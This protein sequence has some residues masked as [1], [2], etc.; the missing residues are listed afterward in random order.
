MYLDLFNGGR[1]IR[2]E[3]YMGVEEGGGCPYRVPQCPMK[4][5]TVIEVL[6]LIVYQ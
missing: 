5:A 4:P 3:T 1:L 2:P 6:S